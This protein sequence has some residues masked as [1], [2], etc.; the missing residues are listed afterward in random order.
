MLCAVWYHFYN[1]KNVKK[2]NSSM[3]FF[4]RFLNCTNRTKSGKASHMLM[5]NCNP[6]K[7]PPLDFVFLAE[8]FFK[9]LFRI[10]F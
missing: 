3:G 8:M 9:F 1:L 4:S 2:Q 10:Y 6:S 5:G 7:V